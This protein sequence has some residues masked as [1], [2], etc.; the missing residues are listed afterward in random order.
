[1]G[2]QYKS[3][4]KNIIYINALTPWTHPDIFILLL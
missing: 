4:N 3:W 2:E 1:M